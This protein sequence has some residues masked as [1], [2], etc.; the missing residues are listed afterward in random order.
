MKHI[1]IE[2]ETC[3][4]IRYDNHEYSVDWGGV[5]EIDEALLMDSMD[6]GM[7][8]GQINLINQGKSMS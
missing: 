1:P 5:D 7:I 8:Y 6:I 2:S 4:V 3:Y